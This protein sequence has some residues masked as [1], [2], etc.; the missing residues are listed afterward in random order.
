MNSQAYELSLLL[1]LQDK[2]SPGVAAF[3][4]LLR[5]GQ[6][7]A[8]AFTSVLDS[9]QRS[10]Q[11]QATSRNPFITSGVNSQID[12]VTS[13]TEKQIGV[14]KRLADLNDRV[15]QPARQI[16]D[17]WRREYDS[18]KDFTDLTTK[19]YREQNKFKTIN[20]SPDQNTKAFTAVDESVRSMGLNTRAE[21][22][23]M[24]TDL[25]TSLGD[26]D[27]AIASLPIASKYRFSMKA[28]FGDQ[29]SD[30]Q[31]DKQLQ[32]TFKY[33]ELTGAAAKGRKSMEESFNAIT[34]I[35]SSTGGRVTGDDFLQF[36]RRAGTAGKD[37][38]PQGLRNISSLMQEMGA[39][40]LGT[41]L[42]SMY[43]ALVGG[44]MKKSAAERFQQLGLLDQSKVEY[45]AG[46]KI[47]RVLP[48]ANQLGD[49]MMEDP[50]AAAD[51]LTSALKAAGVNTNDPKAVN[52]ELATLFQNRTA[53]RLMSSLINQR[54]QVEK[55]ANLAKNSKGVDGLFAQT[56]ESDLA[57]IEK[58]N[59]ALRTFKE[60]AGRPLI[61]VAT[62]VTK[63]VLPLL[64]F[65]AEHPTVTQWAMAGL[66]VGKSLKGIAETASI[67][68]ASGLT[69][70]FTGSANSANVLSNNLGTAEKRAGG[71]RSAIGGLSK[72]SAINIG[73]NI[74]AVV[75]ISALLAWIQANVQ[76]AFDAGAEKSKAETATKGN[77]LTYSIAEKELKQSG[78]AM[79]QKE[80][81]STAGLAWFSAMRMG[82]D[83]ALP[84]KVSEKSF[85]DQLSMVARMTVLSPIT[86]ASGTANPFTRS[87][88][89]N[90]YNTESL[91]A[92]FKATTPQLANASVMREFL[93]QLP[94]RVS[95]QSEQGDI[96][97]ALQ[98][99]F[100]DSYA[101]SMTGM[102][103]KGTQGLV[104][105]LSSLQQPIDQ[106]NLLFTGMPQ[107]LTDT[108]TGFTNLPQPIDTTM[109]SL[110]EL[111]TSANR[112]PPSFSNVF[113]S[114]NTLSVSL[115]GVSAKI[116]SWQ[117]PAVASP[118]ASPFGGPPVGIPAN[119]VGGI[120]E[121]DG[122]AYVHAGNTITPAKKRPYEQRG[123]ASS[124][125]YSPQI[126]INGGGNEAKADFAA[127]LYAH[128]KEIERIVSERNGNG[129]IRG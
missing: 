105:S 13:R 125:V 110:V 103:E 48:G 97:K 8:K 29:F 31:L 1:S 17:T 53:Q 69:G 27:A 121:K 50:L 106:A 72:T 36:S 124:I 58:M 44:V 40:S 3:I 123:G 64:Q 43:Q 113:N 9:V 100:P 93:N 47:K 122:L 6:V 81:E 88:V 96:K 73:V 22:L 49:L 42:A 56:Q 37:L 45:G 77:S 67:L 20:L 39:D 33:L 127:M 84:T 16:G 86:A 109:Q 10:M 2:A 4:S 80:I 112:L 12:A 91:A 83:E 26:L 70:F 102:F 126:T 98:T 61:E 60:E 19:L 18:L 75:G 28:I 57:K 21:A 76:K 79:P 24:L 55:E 63:A 116:S 99:A 65:F 74:G 89:G 23:S 14:V 54:D 107:P 94:S 87:V 25:Y 30:D 118:V 114:A 15:I 90:G 119:A 129:R 59:A 115:D 120:I 68:R 82:L 38:T 52:K 95:S 85:T 111:S 7:E 71:L 41:S 62:S 32:T 78:S 92:G 5:R 34:Q 108:T 117:P 46:N 101:A 128:S 35:S 104:Q 51:K 66:L 11:R